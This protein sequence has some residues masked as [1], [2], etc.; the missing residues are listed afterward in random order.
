MARRGSRLTIPA[1]SQAPTVAL[2]TMAVRRSG[3]TAT[4]VTKMAVSTNAEA[5][6]PTFNVPGMSSS[7]GRP[8]SLKSA[9]VG[10][11]EPIPSASKKSVTKPMAISP[12]V[13]LSRSGWVRRARSHPTRKAML[14]TS[15]TVRKP[16]V[17]QPMLM[18]AQLTACPLRG[19]DPGPAPVRPARA[20]PGSPALRRSGRSEEHTSELQSLRHLVCRLLLEKKKKRN[21]TRKKNKKKK[22]RDQEYKT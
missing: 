7:A 11:K 14:T 2:P 21:R 9:V 8:R 16:A 17:G 1:P 15:S 6:W 20:D 4:D 10:A 22:E 13:A 18:G 12:A 3:S 19:T 5:L